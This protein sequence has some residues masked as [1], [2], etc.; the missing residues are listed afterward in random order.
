MISDGLITFLSSSVEDN[1]KIAMDR[2]Y[3]EL[4]SGSLARR[5]HVYKDMW[6]LFIYD[7]VVSE[8]IYEISVRG[9]SW[10]LDTHNSMKTQKMSSLDCGFLCILIPDLQAADK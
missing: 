8:A 3:F 4:S 1:I 10:T 7:F 5:F 6:R 9:T 2:T